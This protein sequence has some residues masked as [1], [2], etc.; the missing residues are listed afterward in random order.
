MRI[1]C[2]E[3][4]HY[5]ILLWSF[6]DALIVS[7]LIPRNLCTVRIP[8]KRNSCFIGNNYYDNK[9]ISQVMNITIELLEYRCGSPR[10][11]IEQ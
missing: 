9:G 10:T 2:S 6:S 3:K 5:N 8:C 4:I 1:Y 7:L 11:C